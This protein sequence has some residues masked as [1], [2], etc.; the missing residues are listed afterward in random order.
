MAIKKFET[1][2]GINSTGAVVF[3]NTLTV[4]GD[5][6]VDT[7]TLFVDVSAKNVG[8]NATPNASYALDV[9]GSLRAT[10]LYGDGTNITGV[11][12]SDASTLDGIDSTSFLRS[13]AADAYNSGGT[14]SI[15]NNS[16]LRVT[17][18]SIQLN[19]NQSFGIGTGSDVT[20]S[21]DGSQLNVTG[22]DIVFA[23]NVLNLDVSNLTVGINRV[24]SSSYSLD[25]AG[26][27]R[28]TAFAGSG[29]LLTSVSA[30]SAL[31]A[32]NS[33]YLGTFSAAQYLRSDT[34]DTHTSGTLIINSSGIRVNDNVNLSLGTGAD[35]IFNFDGTKVNATGA[36]LAI[37]TNTLFV[38]T[39]ANR[40]GIGKTNPSTALDVSGSITA[41][42]YYGDGSNLTGVTTVAAGG[43]CDTLDGLDSTDFLRSNI[44]DNHTSG[45]LILSGS[46]S[47]IRANDNIPVGFGTG[48]DILFKYD[49]TDLN[50]TGTGNINLSSGNVIIP[51][52]SVRAKQGTSSVD[53][54]TAGFTFVSDADT[55]MFNENISAAS[56]TLVFKCNNDTKLTLSHSTNSATA[57]VSTFTVTGGITCSSLTETSDARLKKDVKSLDGSKVFNMRGVSYTMNGLEGSGVIA[58]ELESIAPELISETKDGYKSVAYGHLVGYLIEAIKELKSEIEELKQ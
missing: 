11:T 41:T 17:S 4:A 15:E 40:V 37:D 10:S 9:A 1:L 18:G 19:D 24:P 16:T 52:G 12:A 21:Y 55:G 6:A 33:S 28:A 57:N 38:D 54:S 42:T 39:S 47:G 5:L 34:T 53:N 31:T 20:F 13:N 22:G 51:N 3:A 45:T 35:F 2:D 43:D 58:Q 7:D 36:N 32:N 46:S 56:G 49:G 26:T 23:N 44:T 50:V 30:S 27:V 14:L 48:S 25:V 8:V 29:A